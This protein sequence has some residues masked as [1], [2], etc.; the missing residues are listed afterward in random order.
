M[1]PKQE[2][3]IWNAHTLHQTTTCLWW[4]SSNA[5][6]TTTFCN[7]Q[8]HCSLTLYEQ[9]HINHKP[10]CSSM[11]AKSDAAQSGGDFHKI[12]LVPNTACRTQGR[13]EA[14][15]KCKLIQRWQNWKAARNSWLHFRNFSSKSISVKMQQVYQTGHLHVSLQVF[16][17]FKFL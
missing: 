2:G 12:L 3:G 6:I 7:G 5:H 17:L 13:A 1:D 11:D 15:H 9:V 16:C 14:M 8:Q 10:T 4:L